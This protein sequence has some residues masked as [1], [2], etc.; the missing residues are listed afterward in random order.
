MSRIRGLSPPLWGLKTSSKEVEI[1]GIF[2]DFRLIP[3]VEIS[4]KLEIY[5]FK[6]GVTTLAKLPQN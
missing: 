6:L 4:L 3:M 2:L 1:F 5:A